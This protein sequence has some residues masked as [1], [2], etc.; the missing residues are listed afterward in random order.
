MK[1]KKYYI[2]GAG[3]GDP[4][5]IT[6]RA[7]KA[8]AESDLVLVDSLVPDD[9]IERACAGKHIMRVGHRV[10]GGHSGIIDRISAII[11]STEFSV[12][13]HLKEGDP[14]VFSHLHE[15]IG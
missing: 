14:S 3:P 12:A 9:V 10:S 6:V 11:D 8:I 13:S 4:G 7:M 15:E 2:I 1:S 5:L